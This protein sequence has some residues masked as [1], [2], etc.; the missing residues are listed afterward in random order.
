MDKRDNKIFTG[1]VISYNGMYG[2]IK[3]DKESIY[4]HKNTV[5]NDVY[6][7]KDDIVQ[8]NVRPSRK[9]K[10]ANEAFNVKV[11]EYGT[12]RSRLNSKLK[13]GKPNVQIGLIKWFEK[14]KGYGVIINNDNEESFVMDKSYLSAKFSTGTAV[15][16]IS[17][18]SKTKKRAK[19]FRLPQTLEDWKYIKEIPEEE[20]NFVINTRCIVDSHYGKWG[21]KDI[22]YNIKAS[23][24][25][26]ILK[27]ENI[28]YFKNFEL[29]SDLIIY[30]A[31]H[32]NYM[33]MSVG[34][35]RHLFPTQSYFDKF[36]QNLISVI[37]NYEER[38][39][40]EQL[41]EFVF[42]D[43]YVSFKSLES[44]YKKK[45]VNTYVSTFLKDYSGYISIDKYEKLWE[46]IDCIKEDEEI[47][48]SFIYENMGLLDLQTLVLLLFVDK[49]LI[50]I[51]TMRVQE[52]FI[53]KFLGS[54]GIYKPS[55][56]SSRLSVLDY[57]ISSY[58]CGNLQN[59]IFKNNNTRK[60]HFGY[61]L[62]HYIE[63]TEFDVLKLILETEE[64]DNNWKYKIIKIVFKLS[65]HTSSK[66]MILEDD[67][68]FQ[69]LYPQIWE[70]ESIISDIK[71]I[72]SD[73]FKNFVTL[74]LE[75]FSNDQIF[76]LWI[77]K[78]ISL[79]SR[80]IINISRKI[81]IKSFVEVCK[82]LKNEDENSYNKLFTEFYNSLTI[83]ENMHLWMNG[84]SDIY[85]YIEFLQCAHSLSVDERKL[86]NK[87]IKEYAK[88][89]RFV[90]FLNQ[91]PNAEVIEGNNGGKIYRCKWRNLYYKDSKVIVFLNKGEA[92]PT[93]NWSPAR[94][95]WNWL[96]NEYFN[97]KYIGDI[98]VHTFN[99][100][101]LNIEGLNN[102]E[103][104]IIV[105]DIQKNGSRNHKS[106]IDNEQLVR[107]VHN[108]AARNKCIDFLGRQKSPYNAIDIQEL[109]SNQ[110]GEIKRDISFMFIIPNGIYAYIV[111]ESVEYEK[112][113]A[114][115]IFR[116]EVKS[117]IL[118]ADIIKD[119]IESNLHIRSRLISDSIED[120]IREE[121]NF[122]AR[123]NHD[124][125][126]F[127]IWESRM[128]EVLPFL[129]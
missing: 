32:N 31:A 101:I 22:P 98:Y 66:R 29:I 51:K 128:K 82:I 35:I 104:R 120:N 5:Y 80:D 121:L 75:T 91:V 94:E 95:E 10:G 126:K 81:N 92:L 20:C 34:K 97:R 44:S 111:W 28:Q 64:F 36:C 114:T 54:L 96:T 52:I 119:Y 129:E 37:C 84:L 58:C 68:T 16:Y 30:Q 127:E 21:H 77:N 53:S 38:Y 71:W 118:H 67:L 102:I 56:Y 26:M 88:Q 63:F 113:K 72:N 19:L 41:I 4:F 78:F 50:N 33:N 12:Y 2:F 69:Y 109:V 42:E 116:C 49:Y 124:S 46:L 13:L 74:N 61:N 6:L 117:A 83:E 14:E 125:I 85:N 99:G 27:E 86:L 25:N 55:G 9:R 107:I 108:V 90:S 23:S 76:K 24:S 106:I 87:R 39:G 115:Y 43:K 105:A 11:I 40:V 60:S 47:Y 89:E 112:S 15:I 70:D 3:Y 65:S 79:D 100:I 110:Y 123:V 62:A 18:E 59:R 1:K 122:Y 8:F 17:D 103:E 73:K 7:C 48:N 57:T 93:Y 45:I